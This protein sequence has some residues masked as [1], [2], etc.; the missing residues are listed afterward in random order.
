MIELLRSGSTTRQTIGFTTTLLLFPKEPFRVTPK[1]QRQSF[2]CWTLEGDG[3]P[4]W[5]SCFLS[6]GL[7]LAFFGATP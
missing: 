7:L 5:G 4:S 2:W 1:P 3:R 6:A